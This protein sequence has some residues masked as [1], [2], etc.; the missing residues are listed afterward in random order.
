VTDYLFP[1]EVDSQKSDE[2][3]SSL[4]FVEQKLFELNYPIYSAKKSLPSS[5]IMNGISLILDT[6]KSQDRKLAKATEERDADALAKIPPWVVGVTADHG[7]LFSLS[8]YVPMTYA[9]TYRRSC[10]PFSMLEFVKVY[11]S[12]FTDRGSAF[13]PDMESIPVDDYERILRGTSLVVWTNFGAEDAY[14]KRYAAQLLGLLQYRLGKKRKMFFL[15]SYDEK[16]Q[17][18][19]DSAA[20]TFLHGTAETN[21]NRAVAD[22]VF[23]NSELLRLE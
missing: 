9:L 3:R 5:K 8:E 6:F 22:I 13:S 16:Q 2:A 17:K 4:S 1:W 23:G 11:Q 20:N 21:L 10:Y 19:S 15:C 12:G 18:K 14:A 7:L